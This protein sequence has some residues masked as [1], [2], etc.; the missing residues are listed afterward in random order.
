MNET[1][2]SWMERAAASSGVLACGARLADRSFLAKSCSEECPEPKVTQA[3]RDLSEAIYALQQNHIAAEHLRWTFEK[4]QIR[5]VAR[6]GG[7]MAAL[8][9]SKES[10]D[11]PQ[12]EQ[13]LADFVLT[14][15]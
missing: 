5:C 15:S 9:L 7:V 12:I 2:Q 13:L 3:L 6:P 8:L 1:V 4:G 10:A 11:L 14:F